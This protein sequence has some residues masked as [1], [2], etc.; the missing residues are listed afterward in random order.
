MT[1]FYNQMKHEGLLEIS[2]AMKLN[3]SLDLWKI[4]VDRIGD[5][6][7]SVIAKALKFNLSLWHDLE[8]MRNAYD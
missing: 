3:S 1:L 4:H 7:P 2:A 8:L 6:R 5:G